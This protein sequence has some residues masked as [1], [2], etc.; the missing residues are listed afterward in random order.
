MN[1]W[2]SHFIATGHWTPK[3]SRPSSR[4][5]LHGGR[6][7]APSPQA[8]ALGQVRPDDGPRVEA[9]GGERRHVLAGPR[10][11]LREEDAARAQDAR[12]AAQ[13]LGVALR[14]EVVEEERL[15]DGV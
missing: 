4:Q 11:A 14:V 8:A 12:D 5:H 1:G 13:Q 2:N 10:L 9:R 6:L 7:V 3:A 15:V